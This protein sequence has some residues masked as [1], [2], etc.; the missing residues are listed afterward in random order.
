[1]AFRTMN[2]TLSGGNDRLTSTHTPV[3]WVNV[4]NPT[5]NSAVLVGDSNISAAVYGFSIG[6]AASGPAIGPLAE[7]SFNLEDI[8]LRGTAS[9]IVRVSYLT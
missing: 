5:G 8:Y 4:Y 6:A 2:K 1:M 9:D 7:P 3:K